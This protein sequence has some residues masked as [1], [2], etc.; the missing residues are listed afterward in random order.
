MRVPAVGGN[1]F[2]Y[3]TMGLIRAANHI[4]HRQK[5]SY[6]E[7]RVP[8]GTSFGETKQKFSIPRDSTRPPYD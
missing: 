6:P 8:L 2:G 5:I 3:I 7:P 1:K 4:G